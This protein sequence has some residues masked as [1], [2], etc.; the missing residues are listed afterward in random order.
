MR[1]LQED[2]SRP[3]EYVASKEA[4]SLANPLLALPPCVTCHSLPEPILTC[5]TDTKSISSSRHSSLATPSPS[6]STTLSS[7]PPLPTTRTIPPSLRLSSASPSPS[8][9][10]SPR[11]SFLSLHSPCQ[12]FYRPPLSPTS[13]S[14]LPIQN[15]SSHSAN[16]FSSLAPLNSQPRRSKRFRRSCSSAHIEAARIRRGRAGLSCRADLR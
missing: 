8:L 12:A 5:A 2:E 13:L 9:L 14:S 4:P 11:P 7:S 3:F 15:P 6:S 16:K 10:H 1:L